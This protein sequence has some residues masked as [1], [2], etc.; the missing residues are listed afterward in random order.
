MSLERKR[1]LPESMVLLKTATRHS[2]LSKTIFSVILKVIGS[3]RTGQ[4]VVAVID[5]AALLHFFETKYISKLLYS[6]V[7]RLSPVTVARN[8]YDISSSNERTALHAF[9]NRTL[10]R[11][12]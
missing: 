11:T 12:Q 2:R 3:C 8:G 4:G 7:L 9:S 6:I 10:S 5:E 1:N